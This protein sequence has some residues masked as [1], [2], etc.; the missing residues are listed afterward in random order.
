[1]TCDKLIFPSAIMQILRHV[2]VS[3]LKSTD[4][5]IKCAIDAMTI[6]RSETQLQLKWPRTETVTPPAS[7]APST[8]V[9]SSSAGGVTLKT[10]MAQLQ[11]MDARLNTLNDELC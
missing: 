11:H 6:R 2:S 4:F 5:S 9:P 7:S 3:Y 10:I 8:S 1:M